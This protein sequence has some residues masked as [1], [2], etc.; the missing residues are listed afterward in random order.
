MRLLKY[1]YITSLKKILKKP[2][3][4]FYFL[5]IL[6]IG[7]IVFLK[8]LKM[9]ISL[10]D[11]IEKNFA[12]TKNYLSYSKDFKFRGTLGILIEKENRQELVTA[13]LCKI[14]SFLTKIFDSSKLI[15][16]NFSAFD[17]SYILE[18]ESIISFKKYLNNPC[19]ETWGLSIL[20]DTS[21]SWTFT[22]S[23][24]SEFIVFFETQEKAGEL[25]F[26][27]IEKLMY[28]ASVS[29]TNY[30]AYWFGIDLQEFYTYK[31][32][33]YSSVLN[34][35][36]SLLIILALRLIT[37]SYLS[38]IV[39]TIFQ[40]ISIIILY[41]G[42]S[43]LGHKL[44][45][46]SVCLYLMISMACLSDYIFILFSNLQEDKPLKNF[47]KLALPCFFTSVTTFLGFISLTVSSLTSIK[48]FGLWAAIG[49][50]L[51]WFLIF[52]VLPIIF[53]R[54]KKFNSILKP[55]RSFYL[56]YMS[57]IDN[58][59]NFKCSIKLAVFFI[60]F[61]PAAFFVS[62]K[63]N[64]TQSPTDTF[65]TGHLMSQSWSKLKESKGWLASVSLIFS[66]GITEI[67]KKSIL[68][69]IKNN[70][71]IESTLTKE[72]LLSDVNRSQILPNS[73][74]LLSF[75]KTSFAGE[76]FYSRFNEE[77]MILNLNSTDYL[78]IL[79][80]KES[81]DEACLET[82]CYLTGE[83]V[84]FADFTSNLIN[85]LFDSLK[86]SLLLVISLILFLAVLLKRLN[87]AFYLI[88]S[89]LWGPSCLLFIVSIFQIQINFVTCIIAATIVGLTGDNSIQYLFANKDL[90]KGIKK[91][92]IASIFSSLLM[93]LNCLMFLFSYFAPP[94]VLG[95]LLSIGIV[96]TLIGDLWF[97]KS[98][99]NTS[100]FKL[101]NK[102]HKGKP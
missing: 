12:S 62:N 47:R 10:E 71:I 46:L 11:Q 37:G 93:A 45:V 52:Y 16:S 69:K 66:S 87:D 77:R 4:V 101:I 94:R 102:N 91:R 97:L 65:P 20:K 58:F 50:M 30:K 85:T 53:K 25:K 28:E 67:E 44:D 56:K 51:E 61:F 68:D 59:F 19:S 40:L 27:E 92:E 39:Y 9:V 2:Q 98:L 83:N 81:V 90:S 60:L 6:V 95:G 78:K 26:K 8:D 89:C 18:K 33:I 42:M 76:M 55:H 15:K 70:K 34:I 3:N 32:M 13:D 7:S 23:S 38:G 100:E 64:F 43:L 49:S 86:M 36:S 22:N 74:S 5:L 14:E 72:E 1:L 82:K 54:V 79:K 17:L 80:L 57:Q 29:L 63:L 24:F 21:F 48:N 75:L 73:N 35:L 88:V 41:G 31:G 96:L 84:A 99:F